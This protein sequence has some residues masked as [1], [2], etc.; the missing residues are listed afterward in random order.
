MRRLG[1]SIYE[2]AHMPSEA[3]PLST[4]C[5]NETVRFQHQSDSTTLF[6][7]SRLERYSA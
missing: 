1:K 5:R 6:L 3:K 4:F 7:P 2:P